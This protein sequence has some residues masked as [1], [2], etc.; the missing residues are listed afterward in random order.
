MDYHEQ[1]WKFEFFLQEL[2]KLVVIE[3]GRRIANEGRLSINQDIRVLNMLHNLSFP[4]DPDNELI[5]YA[6][7]ELAAGRTLKDIYEQYKIEFIFL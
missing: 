5:K 7:R 4:E 6:K 1:D 3:V 2:N